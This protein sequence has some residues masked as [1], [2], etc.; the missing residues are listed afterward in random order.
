MVSPERMCSVLDWGL[1]ADKADNQS[2]RG[3]VEEETSAES[4][5]VWTAAR[6]AEL[7]P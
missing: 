1:A 7:T 5:S 4:D 3:V 2:R 6:G